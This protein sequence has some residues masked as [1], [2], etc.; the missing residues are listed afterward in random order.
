MCIY[1]ESPFSGSRR[2]ISEH[3][4]LRYMVRGVGQA[5]NGD[6]EG[7]LPISASLFSAAFSSL[8]SGEG[9]CYLWRRNLYTNLCYDV[10]KKCLIPLRRIFKFY[11]SLERGQYLNLKK[12]YIM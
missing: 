3:F 2:R 5:K 4:A 8:C 12:Y 1:D 11:I 6:S 7:G 9:S 10:R